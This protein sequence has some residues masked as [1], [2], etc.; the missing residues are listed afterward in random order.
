MSHN[1]SSQGAPREP[2]DLAKI[3]KFDKMFEGLEG[4]SDSKADAILKGV[5]KFFGL[6]F[7]YEGKTIFLSRE[8]SRK[9]REVLDIPTGSF[10]GPSLKNFVRDQVQSAIRQENIVMTKPLFEKALSKLGV[11]DPGELKK[12]EGKLHVEGD[13]VTISRDDLLEALK[14]HENE[15]HTTDSRYRSFADQMKNDVHVFHRISRPYQEKQPSTSSTSE[16]KL[17]PAKEP[18]KEG[19]A[20]ELKLPEITQGE[21][22]EANRV[23]P[24][25]TRKNFVR[26]IQVPEVREGEIGQ[27]ERRLPEKPVIKEA[28]PLTL[29]QK[30]RQKE[31]DLSAARA[32]FKE[33]T[34][35]IPGMKSTIDQIA[36]SEIGSGREAKEAIDRID[37]E[38]ASLK[39]AVETYRS[40]AQG[41]QDKRAFDADYKEIG[42]AYEDLINSAEKHK[43]YLTEAWPAVAWIGDEPKPKEPTMAERLTQIK[44]DTAEARSSFLTAGKEIGTLKKTIE[45]IGKK[46]DSATE[47]EAKKGVQEIDRR[48]QGILKAFETYRSLAKGGDDLTTFQDDVKKSDFDKLMRTANFQKDQLRKVYVT[49]ATIQETVIA[50]ESY[51]E[52][53]ITTPSQDSETVEVE[54]PRRAYLVKGQVPK[55]PASD[56]PD[57]AQK[58]AED[59]LQAVR[60]R[61]DRVAEKSQAQTPTETTRP[62][63][64]ERQ[65]DIREM[66]KT[67]TRAAVREHFT[68]LIRDLEADPAFSQRLSSGKG[69]FRNDE[70]FKKWNAIKGEIAKMEDENFGPDY[71]TYLFIGM[72]PEYESQGFP[73]NLADQLQQFYEGQQPPSWL[74]QRFDTLAALLSHLKE[75]NSEGK[76]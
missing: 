36:E 70:F 6:T 73:G 4:F 38:L 11:R 29:A 50:P 76:E 47:A 71:L 28:P 48:L 34:Q 8:N 37:K 59:A 14:P 43:A 9:I 55:A 10:V 16:K 22:G 52:V 60:A 69:V 2:I 18:P 13:T 24:Q 54:T 5:A 3:K 41:G 40:I 49:P 66:G 46:A 1:I 63:Y 31:N 64:A 21:I 12:L 53:I 62:A 7:S 39:Q 17:P 45:Q 65:A 25:A 15:I 33:I 68:A 20:E 74:P 19:R 67:E 61:A 42:A 44:K 51:E 56:M 27:A 75:V 72:E 35:K 23:L 57:V 26:E 32:A 30:L 58:L